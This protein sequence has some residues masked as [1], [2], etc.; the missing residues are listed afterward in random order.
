MNFKRERSRERL[1]GVSSARVRRFARILEAWFAIHGRRF[2]WR[3]KRLSKYRT[4]VTEILLQRTRA[5][6]VAGFEGSFFRRYP[7]WR[8]LAVADTREI[9][10]LLRP[11]GL[12]RRRADGLRGLAK[13][14]VL[15]RGV[16]PADRGKLEALPCVGQYV[17]NAI[18][19]FVHGRQE[20]LLDVNM[21][22]LLQRYF[23]PRELVD[24]RDDPYLQGLSRSVV[25]SGQPATLNW[26]ML[27]FA[28][29]ICRPSM[30]RCAECPLSRAC[31]Y[32]N[33]LVS[34]RPD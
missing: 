32:A 31:R 20:P 23:G 13:E 27:D 33:G 16:F 12:W 19:L 28:A 3:K 11:I 7:G 5:E 15:R 6:T 34:A 25:S 10:S 2:P 26:A 29:L 8:Q 9:G 14:M 22:R 17:A 21:A 1:S 18:L 30:P 24:I 4:V